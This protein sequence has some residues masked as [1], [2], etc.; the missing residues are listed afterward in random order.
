MNAR[1]L[2]GGQ[3]KRRKGPRRKS[4]KRAKRKAVVKVKIK[5][6]PEQVHAAVQKIAKGPVPEQPME[7]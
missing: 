3:L 6:T 7:M 5:G 4:V 2:M 1:T